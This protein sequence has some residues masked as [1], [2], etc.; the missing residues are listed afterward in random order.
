MQY[1]NFADLEGLKAL[2]AADNY[3]GKKDQA[4]IKELRA[5]L[6]KDLEAKINADSDNPQAL[7]EDWEEIHQGLIN[8]DKRGVYV[9]WQFIKLASPGNC[10]SAA[11]SS[12]AINL[13]ARPDQQQISPELRMMIISEIKAALKTFVSALTQHDIDDCII[14]F[15]FDVHGKTVDQVREMTIKHVDASIKAESNTSAES[16]LIILAMLAMF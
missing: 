3:H 15:P 6:A 10:G 16:L 12:P 14:A 9:P 11:R 1:L 8:L 4:H 7:L 13:A 5:F 2:R